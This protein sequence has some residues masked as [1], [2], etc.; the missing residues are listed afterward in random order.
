MSAILTAMPL[1][2]SSEETQPLGKE[3]VQPCCEL[4]P[5]MAVYVFPNPVCGE[6]P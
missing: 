3:A 2:H 1:Q 4:C 6:S 5:M